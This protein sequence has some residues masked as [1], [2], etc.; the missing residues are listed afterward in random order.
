MKSRYLTKFTLISVV[1]V[2]MFFVVWWF[3]TAGLKILPTYIMPDP[4]RVFQTLY[5]K[6]YVRTPDG[7]TLVTHTVASLEVALLGFFAGSVTGIPLGICMAWYKMVDRV[8]RPIF[9]FLRPIPPIAWIPVMILWFGIG[10]SAKAAVIFMASFIPNVINSYTGIR[11]TSQVHIWV[12]RTFGA[13]D[14]ELL[15][16]VAIPS[17]LPNIFTGLRLSL[18]TSWVSL[19]SAE[20]LA[21]TRGLGYM[22]QIGRQFSRIDLVI[23][24]MVVIGFLGGS[25]AYILEAVQKRFVKGR[26]TYGK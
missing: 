2:A 18:G 21:S 6:F 26:S 7:G 8:A 11:Q 14:F 5:R 20:M 4:V 13:S 12:G 10:I 22:I 15:T 1:S 23:V 19:V 9:D 16:R 24:G 3:L 17:A 25:L